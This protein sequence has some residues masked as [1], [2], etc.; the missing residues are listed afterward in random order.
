M[1]TPMR[2]LFIIKEKYLLRF[3]YKIVKSVTMLDYSFQNVKHCKQRTL[4]LI[5]KVKNS[6]HNNNPD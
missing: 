2:V 1:L 6:H 5:K 3:I 4:K